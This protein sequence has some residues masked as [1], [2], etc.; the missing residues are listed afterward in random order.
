V[1]F[2]PLPL[3]TSDVWFDAA[4][5]M[6]FLAILIL[7]YRATGFLAPR[8]MCIQPAN[9]WATNDR[10]V[11]FRGGTNT[12][13]E[14]RVLL[15]ERDHRPS[16]RWKSVQIDHRKLVI[17]QSTHSDVPPV[18]VLVVDDEKKIRTHIENALNSAGFRVEVAEDANVALE[19][20]VNGS[21][22]VIVLDIMLPG[23]DGL[24]LLKELRSVGIGTPVLAVS[25]RGEVG[26]RVQGL[27]CGADDYLPKPFVLA[28]VVARVRALARRRMVAK[29]D[30]LQVG[31][32]V[33]DP[34]KRTARRGGQLI[35]LATREYKLLDFLMRRSGQICGRSAILKHVWE[36]NFDPGTNLVEVYIM[37]I[38]E[39]ID[40]GFE[41]KLL[42]T[43]RGLGYV[44]KEAE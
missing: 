18:R 32:L 16:V 39:K 21:F 25:A 11:I 1:R 37:R 12:T 40:A 41:H 23:R 34:F 4:E 19:R 26:E 3:N 5:F 6:V 44:L 17:P 35:N 22:D 2:T 33:L 38:R 36:Y 8:S 29:G 42:H 24:N 15:N 13:V 14:Y 27:D 28:E 20:I 10:I 31:D 43:I 9:G 30:V 7:I